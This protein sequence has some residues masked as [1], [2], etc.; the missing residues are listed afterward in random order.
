MAR[1]AGDTKRAAAYRRAL[2]LAAKYVVQNHY[3]AHNSYG[4][5]APA[6]AI[7]GFRLNP[8]N[9]RVRIDYV[10]HCASFLLEWA[11]LR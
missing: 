3:H 10:Q 11:S 1:S 9:C 5:P 6:R 7:G 4:L 8:L 2:Q